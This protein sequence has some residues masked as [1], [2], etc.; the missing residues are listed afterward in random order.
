MQSHKNEPSVKFDGFVSITTYH[1]H[2]LLAALQQKRVF[3]IN[4]WRNSNL[5]ATPVTASQEVATAS[6]RGLAARSLTDWQLKRN[7]N[8]PELEMLRFLVHCFGPMPVAL[9]SCW[10]LLRWCGVPVSRAEQS[11]P[12]SPDICSVVGAGVVIVIIITSE[13]VEFQ[14]HYALLANKI[15]SMN[16]VVIET[17]RDCLRCWIY[18]FGNSLQEGS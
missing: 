7:Y 3:V 1:Q 16:C 11:L 6:G 12:I 5:C 17:T 10:R 15:L 18:Q 13:G 4:Q 14:G 9:T 2:E 8:P